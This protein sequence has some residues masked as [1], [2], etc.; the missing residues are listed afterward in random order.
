MNVSL[1]QLRA[2]VAVAGTGSFT[3]A[4]KQLHITQ[5]ALSL[6]IKDLESELG[7]R[8]L[9][10]AVGLISQGGGEGTP[11]DETLAT[12]EPALTARKALSQG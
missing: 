12:W 8:L 4:A 1:R 5:S 9:D 7:V 2:F 11:Q 3:G 6:L 10:Q